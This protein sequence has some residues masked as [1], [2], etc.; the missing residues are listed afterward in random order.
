[1]HIIIGAFLLVY[2]LA[3]IFSVNAGASFWGNSQQ[4]S[5]SLLMIICLVVFYL[6]VSN[7]FSKKDF[8]TA[9][10]YLFISV[11]IAQ[12]IGVFQIFGKNILLFD[13]AKI[14]IF[15]T[16]G[17]LSNLVSVSLI[18][19][20]LA[21]VLLANARGWWKMLFI[22]QIVLSGGLLILINFTMF[23]WIAAAGAAAVLILELFKKDFIDTRWTII[24]MFFLISALFFALFNPQ[25]N[26]VDFRNKEI[27]FPQKISL[28]ISIQALKERPVLGSGPGTFAYDF[29]KFKSPDFSKSSIWDVTFTK[30][31][32]KVFDI[33]ITT[34]ILGLLALLVLIGFSIFEGIKSFFT[35]LNEV[36]ATGKETN[37]N[38][39]IL[40]LGLISSLVA[41]TAI[42]F[43]FNSNVAIDFI[44]FFLISGLVL[45]IAGNKKKYT[46]KSSSSIALLIT[47][48]FTAV[49]IFGTGLLMFGVQRY[50]AEVNYYKGLQ[51]SANKD[52]AGFIKY[53]EKAVS[54]NSKS[55]VYLRQLSQAYLFA[56]QE[57][58]KNI[59]SEP[60]DQQ[61]MKAQTYLANT[62]NAAKFATDINPN[63][64][65]NW[66]SRAFVYQKLSGILENASLWAITSYDSAIKVDP[67]NPYLYLQKGNIYLNESVNPA[68]AS[69]K[70]QFLDKAKEQLEKA[71]TLNPNYSDALYFLG[72][73]YESL[74][75]KNNAISAFTRIQQLNPTD[76]N[77]AK[78]I[79]DLKASK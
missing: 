5:A 62:V 77:I 47:F 76:K 37:R 53:L 73:T 26:L 18:L 12:I 7:V 65:V 39:G 16:V 58:I 67:N 33:L 20:P 24:P 79:S 31:A 43:L 78:I 35:E 57:E 74:G 10:N 42:F 45:F 61:K 54:L 68:N 49:F 23:W 28:D 41:T 14:G 59:K 29:S 9:V 56:L 8:S 72:L 15:S 48:V 6:L 21:I 36:S 34:G 22:S 52:I 2:T 3:T 71:V 30:P 63:D 27:F 17:L 64:S 60:T 4:I 55:D 70:N 44:W 13:F 32:S 46:L 69:Q 75:Q 51:A 19:L 50:I 66:S 1:L 11:I 40:L 38:N 25:I